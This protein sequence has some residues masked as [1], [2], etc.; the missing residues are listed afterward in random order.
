MTETVSALTKT[1]IAKF[2]FVWF[3]AGVGANVFGES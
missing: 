2:T 1:L 3:L